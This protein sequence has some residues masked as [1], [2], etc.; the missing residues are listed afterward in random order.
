[1]AKFLGKIKNKSKKIISTSTALT[2][3]LGSSLAYARDNP[4]LEE[5]LKSNSEVY[6]G[7]LINS[8]IS[9]KTSAE[10]ELPN[11]INLNW[12]KQELSIN[13]SLDSGSPGFKYSLFDNGDFFFHTESGK[14][15]PVLKTIGNIG[16]LISNKKLKKIEKDILKGRFKDTLLILGS[17]VTLKDFYEM[18]KELDGFSK[19]R[20]GKDFF[21]YKI[22]LIGDAKVSNLFLTNQTFEYENEK[23]FEFYH[24][25]RMK[26]EFHAR[27]F[28]DFNANFTDSIS[29]RDFSKI[30]FS[31]Y[32]DEISLL[33]SEILNQKLK[34]VKL[35]ANAGINYSHEESFLEFAQFK[36]DGILFG[37][38]QEDLIKKSSPG[39]YFSGFNL[40]PEKLS[41]ELEY[42][43]RHSEIKEERRTNL[44]FGGLNFKDFLFLSGFE[45][46]SSRVRTKF[47][48]TGSGEKIDLNE[49]K[50]EDLEKKIDK[51][52]VEKNEKII[53]GATGIK[54]F[55]SLPKLKTGLSLYALTTNYSDEKTE[56]GGII[57]NR[58]LN[59][60][61][62][63][64]G[65]YEG[66]L[67]LKGNFNNSFL[68]YFK[69]QINLEVNPLGENF[70]DSE[71]RT[72]LRD[73]NGVF[74]SGSE[75]KDLQRLGIIFSFK[76]DS[77]LD[78]N[79]TQED[80][81]KEYNL[82]AGLGN[83]GINA[84]YRSFEGDRHGE[85]L[86]GGIS[87][88]FKNNWGAS[89]NIET[90][91]DKPTEIKGFS[92]GISGKF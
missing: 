34:K 48:Q 30:N 84:S 53:F 66:F 5:V 12:E 3:F 26:H 40:D 61:I 51:T 82:M 31:E 27:A 10:Y 29:L 89:F 76:N 88:N 2:M 52:K 37:M 39:G 8:E 47:N 55:L 20:L 17:N 50:S 59:S 70:L 7:K 77:Y 43:K 91:K 68:E 86:S 44:F 22:D 83:F 23:K 14:E 25:A 90:E 56:I 71:K 11:G 60:R 33:S 35:S 15:I 81:A 72:L 65:S 78:F 74:L 85:N 63:T 42:G 18:G 46:E 45:N 9:N 57:K 49:N 4:S 69:R 54:K 28:F 21:N 92:I 87:Y 1:M 73:L 67:T 32:I 38:S 16:D 75:N 64:N 41:I 6:N 19:T 36:T 13:P 80:G 62:N 79:R 24:G 58:L